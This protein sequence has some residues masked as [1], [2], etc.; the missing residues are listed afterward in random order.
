MTPPVPARPRGRV[1][2]LAMAGITRSV[3]VLGCALVVLAACGSSSK[4]GGGDGSGTTVAGPHATV[5]AD[6][7][8]NLITQ[9]DANGLFG[10]DAQRVTDPLEGKLAKSSCLWGATSDDSPAFL[11]QVRVYDR[12]DFYSGSVKGYEPL[13]GLGDRAAISVTPDGTEV[14]ISYQEGLTVTSV[15]YGIHEP[16]GRSIVVPKAEAQKDQ[17][18]AV[19]KGAAARAKN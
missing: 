3:V 19:V 4:S 10:E 17:L 6:A 7:A 18:I 14:T 9:T 15:S 1:S 16:K 11:L 5:A 2:V 8:C 13:A 12:P